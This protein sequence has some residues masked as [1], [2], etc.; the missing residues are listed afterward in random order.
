MFLSSHFT[1][2]AICL[3][4]AN[5]ESPNIVTRH[6]PSWVI[7]SAPE[8]SLC[9]CR[10]VID[11][12]A[13]L[14]HR[15]QHGAAKLLASLGFVKVD[16][17]ILQATQSSALPSF[18]GLS[19]AE[20]SYLRRWQAEARR[21]GIDGVE[22]LAHRPWPC[23]VQ[24]VVIGVFGHGAEAAQWLVIGQNCSWAVAHCVEGTVSPPFENLPEALATIYRL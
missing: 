16:S 24:G 7:A 12:Q 4:G 21:V 20:R 1:L 22:D 8:G 9:S 17:S 18:S 2:R 15:L 19:A 11:G 3:Q 13:E 10:H 14:A 6:R 5:A 23:P